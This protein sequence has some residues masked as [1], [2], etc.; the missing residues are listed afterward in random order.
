MGRDHFGKALW[1]PALFGM[2]CSLGSELPKIDRGV[3]AGAGNASRTIDGTLA[4]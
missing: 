2:G 4:R 3:G 1:R